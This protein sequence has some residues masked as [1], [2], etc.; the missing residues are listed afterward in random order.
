M[1]LTVYTAMAAALALVACGKSPDNASSETASPQAKALAAS[2]EEHPLLPAMPEVAPIGGKPATAVNC[3]AYSVEMVW[4][5]AGSSTAIIL[6]DSQGPLGDIPAGME[7][8]AE[9]GRTLPL[10]AAT[11]ALQMTAG[12]EEMAK[13]APTA[14]AELGGPDF[15]STVKERDGL[16]Y[17][18]EVEPKDAGGRV[19]TL[20]G[21]IKDRYALTMNIEQDHLVGLAAGEAAYGPFLNAMKISK[22]P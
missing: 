17:S 20:I 1:K 9:M 8:M 10:Q 16:R 22:L 15:L 6:V 5:E 2:C 14:V 12:V 13:A 11:T 7:Q 3:E 18:I 19:G 4:G 21:T